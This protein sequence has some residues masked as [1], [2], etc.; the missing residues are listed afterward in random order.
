[1]GNVEARRQIT[2]GSLVKR[3]NG[4][5]YL[6]NKG[7]MVHNLLVAHKALEN[8]RNPEITFSMSKAMKEN[9]IETEERICGIL[10]LPF[11]EREKQK[12]LEKFENYLD[13]V[14]LRISRIG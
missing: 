8:V 5:Y 12:I 14:G 2:E 7:H 3:A 6:T 1:M 11:E 9:Y 4:T 10:G 13:E